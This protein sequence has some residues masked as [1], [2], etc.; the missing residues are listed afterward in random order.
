MKEAKEKKPGRY[1]V[2]KLLEGQFEPGSRGRVLKNLLGIKSKREMD[3]VEAKEQ[4]RAVDELVE[5][6]DRSHQF[7]AGDI[8]GRRGT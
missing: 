4:L 2:S 6:Y 8:Y 7:T 1:D 5:I 3:R